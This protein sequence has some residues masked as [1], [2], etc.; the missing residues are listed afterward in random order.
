MEFCIS[1][2]PSSFTLAVLRWMTLMFS[3]V[4]MVTD[5]K[6]KTRYRTGLE[7]DICYLTCYC[8]P[9]Q[10]TRNPR[11]FPNHHWDTTPSRLQ[12]KILRLPIVADDDTRSVNNLVLCD[13]YVE[14]DSKVLHFFQTSWMSPALSGI[15]STFFFALKNAPREIGLLPGFCSRLSVYWSV[16]LSQCSKKVT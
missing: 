7:R 2:Y 3:Y 1:G 14:Y 9:K 5:I 12:K 16:E 11:K 6:T 15:I 8:P 10:I 4:C 13:I